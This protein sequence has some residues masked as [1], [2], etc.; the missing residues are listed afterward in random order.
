MSDG[1][2]LLSSCSSLI[3]FLASLLEAYHIKKALDYAC[4]DA[5]VVAAADAAVYTPGYVL[6]WRLLALYLSPSFLLC[7]SS[8]A[9]GRKYLGKKG[10]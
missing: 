3:A 4:V 7:S 5:I 6:L 10:T 9:M 2:L 1:E 8:N